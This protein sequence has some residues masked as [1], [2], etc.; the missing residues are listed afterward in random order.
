MVRPH[1]P[2]HFGSGPDALI[3]LQSGRAP[4]RLFPLVEQRSVVVGLV[5]SGRYLDGNSMQ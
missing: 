1:V 4:P 5:D 3:R 2:T